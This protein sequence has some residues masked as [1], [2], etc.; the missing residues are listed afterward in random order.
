MDKSRVLALFIGVVRAGSFSQAALEAGL[1]PQA[2]SKAVRQLE[3]HLGYYQ[4]R[5]Q[6]PQRVRQFI[7]DAAE[8]APAYFAGGPW[9]GST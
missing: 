7:D 8:R 9:T 5:T 6:M 2:V 4:Q 1:S 3:Q